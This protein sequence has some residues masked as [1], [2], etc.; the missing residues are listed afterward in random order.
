MAKASQAKRVKGGV[1]YRGKKYPGFNKPRSS[2]KKDKKRVVLAKK[3]DQI[4]V[5]HFGQKGYG[6]N[7]S[8]DARKSYLARSAGIRDKSGK[9]TKDNKFSANYWARRVLWAGKSGSKARPTRRRRR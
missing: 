2:W 6:H 7:Y 3:G 5:I 8:E 4:K 1:I 9:L